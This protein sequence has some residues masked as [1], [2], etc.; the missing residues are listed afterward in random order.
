MNE[1]CGDSLPLFQEPSD[2]PIFRCPECGNEATKDNYDYLGA[3]DPYR[4]CRSIADVLA[5]DKA[6]GG[7]ATTY[8]FCNCCNSQVAHKD[9]IE[10]Q[11]KGT[12]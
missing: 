5:V 11:P 2:E 4:D 12:V 10:V 6:A 1:L 7:S 3:D 9:L 8:C